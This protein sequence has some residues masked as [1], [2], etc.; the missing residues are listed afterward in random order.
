MAWSGLPLQVTRHNFDEVLPAV[1]AALAD[2]HF[3]AL[4]CEMTGLHVRDQRFSF[5]ADMQDQY[6]TV[7]VRLLQN[8]K[9]HAHHVLWT[10]MVWGTLPDGNPFAIHLS[11][12]ADG[13]VGAE[14]PANTG[15]AVGIS[16]GGGPQPVRRADV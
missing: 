15:R 10:G 16:M 7:I 9:A 5:H 6:T 14:L 8:C 4:D 1:R 2:C 12:H 13:G 11:L 3:F